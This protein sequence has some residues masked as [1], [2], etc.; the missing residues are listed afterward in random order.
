MNFS[1]I[2]VKLSHYLVRHRASKGYTQTQMAKNLNYSLSAFRGFERKNSRENRVLSSLEILQQLAELEGMTI[3]EFVSYL[4]QAEPTTNVS[5]QDKPLRNWEK[6]LLM[7]LRKCD[8]SL[9]FNW[10]EALLG[11]SR[12]NLSVL[13][14]AQAQLAEIDNPQIL[15]AISMLLKRIK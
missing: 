3:V 4:T 7:T 15:T 1:E 8:Q 10:S 6:E 12:K 13:L 5:N 11:F 14:H 9:R 2:Q